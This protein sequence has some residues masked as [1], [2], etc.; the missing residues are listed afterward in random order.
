MKNG[1]DTRDT[2]RQICIVRETSR[3]NA[4]SSPGAKAKRAVV[5]WTGITLTNPTTRTAAVNAALAA[6]PTTIATMTRISTRG[7]CTDRF[8]EWC[9]SIRRRLATSSRNSRR[10]GCPLVIR[11]S[12]APNVH[13]EIARPISHATTSSV[14][15]ALG[16]TMMRSGRMANLLAAN[17][18]LRRNCRSPRN[19]PMQA[20]SR[21]ISTDVSIPSTAKITMCR[22]PVSPGRSA[23]D[24]EA[25]ATPTIA[26]VTSEN[27][28]TTAVDV[29]MSERAWVRSWES[30]LIRRVLSPS[31]QKND[32][33]CA[34]AWIAEAVPTA[35]SWNHAGCDEPVE[36]AEETGDDRRAIEERGIP[37]DGPAE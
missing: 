12:P 29:R 35:A 36:E 24:N 20:S 6:G 9:P 18:V 33:T 23:G 4:S 7:S 37:H 8:N 3:C 11:T 21:T 15:D 13:I 1:A 28:P 22:A 19:N 2:T 30:S 16:H 14:P 34:A 31:M 27:M 26:E 10:A 5:R 17:T 25:S 32:S